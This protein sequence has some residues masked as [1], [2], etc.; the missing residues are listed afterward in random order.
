MDSLAPARSALRAFGSAEFLSPFPKR[1]KNSPGEKKQ[2]L[3][4]ISRIKLLDWP[5]GWTNN[6]KM[7]QGKILSQEER[8]LVR[9][10]VATNFLGPQLFFCGL[11]KLDRREVWGRLS[12]T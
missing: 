5:D 12:A 8:T 3:P 4:R 7:C 9:A 10:S 11:V 1:L 2:P 6:K